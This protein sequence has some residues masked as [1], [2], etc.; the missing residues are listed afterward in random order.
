VV[1]TKA[2]APAMLAAH[3]HASGVHTHDTVPIVCTLPWPMLKR[4]LLLVARGRWLV[5]RFLGT[6]LKASMTAFRRQPWQC[7]LMDMALPFDSEYCL[8]A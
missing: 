5:R 3:H 1:K 8:G 2:E 6:C 7:L 4:C